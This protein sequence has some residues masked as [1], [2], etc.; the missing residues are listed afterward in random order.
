L[1]NLLTELLNSLDATPQNLST[2]NSELNALLGKV[3]G[4]LNASKLTLA[5]NALS[6]LSPV[7]QQ[8][9]LPNL[10]N[11]TG[12]AEAPVLNLD[13]DTTAAPSTRPARPFTR[14]AASGSI[15]LGRQAVPGRPGIAPGGDLSGWNRP[16]SACFRSW[17][18][19]H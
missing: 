19:R 13:P 17:L 8:L 10:V 16:G 4:V 1:G 11:P 2:L 9:A 18:P 6:L 14:R 3:I 12:T 7:L 5:P 15:R